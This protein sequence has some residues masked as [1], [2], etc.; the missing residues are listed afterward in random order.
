MANP[1]GLE[2]A[3]S[4]V[5]VDELIEEETPP[6]ADP[7]TDLSGDDIIEGTEASE[8][9]TG[10]AGNDMIEGRG[11]DD[12]LWGEAGDDSLNG[13]EGSDDLYGGSGG[14]FL[15]GDFGP[16]YVSG[17]DGDDA[18]LGGDDD[19]E[20]LGGQGQ[21]SLFGEDGR[22]TLRGGTQSDYLEG[23]DGDDFLVGGDDDD[24]LSGGSGVD[25]LYGGQGDDLIDGGAD[26]DFADG[27]DGNDT[28]YGG[29]GG[30]LLVG[31]SGSDLISGDVG[32]DRIDG[33]DGDDTLSGGLGEDIISGGLG[34]DTVLYAGTRSDYSIGIFSDET[35]LAS[36]LEGIDV[37]RGV[38]K[39]IFQDGFEQYVGDN[40]W[41][42][43]TKPVLNGQK[44]STDSNIVLEF[45]EPIVEGLGTITL[46]NKQLGTSVEYL[47][48]ENSLFTIQ[49]KSLIFDPP[50]P[51]NI[52]T[53]YQIQLSAGAV[54]DR[55]GL[56]NFPAVVNSFETAT[57]DG[58]YHFFV[59][60]FS[61]APGAIYM[62]QLGEAFDYFKVQSPADPLKPIVDIFTTKNQFTG[63]YPETLSTTE[64]ATQLVSNVVK[65]SATAQAKANAIA[66]IEAAIGIGWTRGDVIYRVFGNLATKPLQDPE[67]GNTALQFRNQLEVARYLT[68]TLHYASEDVEV[69]RQSI[70][71]VTNLSDV[72][73]IENIVELI[74][75]LPP[76]V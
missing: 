59:V 62:S 47:V 38:E 51:L 53:E 58:L 31:G 64:F 41:V 44:V 61:A 36:K 42:M 11:G 70:A 8:E 39:L 5:V 60:A 76:G 19:D 75:T 22:D 16:D 57:V 17:E 40:P 6:L 43:S 37:L 46:L 14:D 56:E 7:N 52:F 49:G 21:D 15:Q 2:V 34:F 55:K 72:S 33:G 12:S 29:A 67:W 13:G 69:L 27:G 48:R 45:S 25:G 65:D 20:L 3:L 63:V 9:F 73:T 74:G 71:N 10:G 30:D 54:K 4:T 32:D 18:L 35:V 66:D 24:T 1:I 26:D 50:Y 68:E 28:I 23:G